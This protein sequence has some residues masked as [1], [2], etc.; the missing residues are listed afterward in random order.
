MPDGLVRSRIAQE[1]PIGGPDRLCRVGRMPAS[2]QY[3]TRALVRPMPRRENSAPGIGDVSAE[4]SL[5][6]E[7]AA[8]SAKHSRVAA[9]AL[10]Q[11]LPFLSVPNASV[12]ASDDNFA[13]QGLRLSNGQLPVISVAELDR[14]LKGAVEQATGRE[15]VQGEISGLRIAASGHAYFTLKDERVDAAI[16]CVMY[17]M[18]AQRSRH[19]LRDGARVQLLGRATIWAP[20]GRLQLVAERLQPVGRGAL[21]E[22]LEALKA[23]L[24]AEGLFAAE[25]K[26]P[27]PARARC[28]GVVT[29]AHGA[30]FRDICAVI[31]RRASTH[32]VLAPALV[33]GD[34]AV[35]SLLAAL[36]LIE[37]HPAIEVLIIG[38]GGGSF[39][40]L[41][42]FNDERIVRRLS[43]FRVPVISAVGHEIDTGLTDLVA[44]R[45]AATPSEA[46][47]LAV[48]D[49]HA[50]VTALSHQTLRLR[51]AMQ[52]RIEDDRAV[53]F[54]FASR[55]SDPRFLIALRQQDLDELWRS[56]E[57]GMQRHSTTQRSRL[58]AVIKR[59]ERRH[60]STVLATERSRLVPLELRLRQAV[61][62]R[63]GV[64]RSRLDNRLA[65]LGALSPVAI[66]ARGYSITLGPDGR[67][68]TSASD[69]AVGDELRVRLSRGSLVA[70]VKK[71]EDQ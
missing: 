15:W 7:V 11:G 65:Q 4:A 5:A 58:E 37:R 17:R 16:D 13:S 14:R 69:V 42:A 64:G 46:A 1:I 43:R 24:F 32:V 25:R 67:A 44:D 66:L 2:F 41:M 22:A 10:L 70:S 57:R 55:L 28:V 38:R 63:L 60:P 8:I 47:E 40:D 49:E 27:L 36:D 50:L 6:G 34:G 23:K 45:R 12:P 26:R 62:Q 39:E 18:A 61:V 48:P 53:R 51:Q 19:H 29:S 68:V 59:L 30:A 56:I 35:S 21:L 33:Q 54:R 9:C 52:R 3:G 20:R 71:M 31:R